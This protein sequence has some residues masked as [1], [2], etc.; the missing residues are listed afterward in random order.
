[1][2]HDEDAYTA[3]LTTLQHEIVNF[4]RTFEKVQEDLRLGSVVESQ[5]QLV[6]AVGDTFRRFDSTFAPL[7]PPESMKELHPRLVAAINE[8]GKSLNLFMTKPNQQWT[9]SFLYSRR[10]FCNGLYALYELRDQLPIVAAH[11][12]MPGASA[13]VAGTS[14]VPTGF[15]QH[16]RND[17]HSDYMLYIPEDYSPEKPLTLIVALHGG[18]GQGSEYVWT[19]LRPARSRGYAILA[20]KS[21]GDTWDMSVPSYDTRSVVRMFDEVARE[22]AI[23]HSRVYLTGLSDGGIFTYILGLERSQLFRGLAP[24]AGALHMV[25]D[26]MLRE[27]RGKDTPLLVIHGVHDFIFPVTFTRQTC[28]LLTQ[29]GYNVKYEE[30]PDWGHAFPYSINERMVLPWFEG[31]PPKQS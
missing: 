2:A 18:Y 20:P 7:T 6:A 19:W 22:Y 15:I 8:L 9:L 27:G 24:V 31:L 17:E 1:M 12:L 25:V 30:L 16:Q 21:L 28:N 29:I 11:F 3:T 10:A 4:L 13:P 26:Q 14:G 5:A 23:D